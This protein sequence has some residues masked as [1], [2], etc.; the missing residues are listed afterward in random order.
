MLP[1]YYQTLIRKYSAK[2]VLLSNHG[3]FASAPLPPDFTKRD[4][5][6]QRILAIGHWGTYKRL[7]TLMEAFPLVLKKAP[8]AKLVVAGANHHT[9]P[10]YWESIRAA[11]PSS[12][13]D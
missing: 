12:L 5:P 3:T 7:E 11:Q 1:G 9:K 10:G 2:N 8:H 6:D 13:P 4:N